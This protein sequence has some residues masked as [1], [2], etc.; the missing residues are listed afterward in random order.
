M[1]SIMQVVAELWPGLWRNVPLRAQPSAC[2]I[3]GLSYSAV[4]GVQT[5]LPPV[6]KWP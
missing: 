4:H 2:S 3:A 1:L 5:H 6:G